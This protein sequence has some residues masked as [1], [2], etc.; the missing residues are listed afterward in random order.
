MSRHVVTDTKMCLA[1]IRKG[2]ANRITATTAMNEA[3]SRSH[4]ILTFYFEKG[5]AADPK[6]RVV[7]AKLNLVDLAGSEKYQEGSDGTGKESKAINQSLYCLSRV[8]NALTDTSIKSLSQAHIPYRDSK[9]TRL[10]KVGDTTMRR[11]L[12]NFSRNSI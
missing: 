7:S 4:S 6:R 12:H 10:L 3:S 9:L 11:M 8:I 5:Q 1:L 2:I